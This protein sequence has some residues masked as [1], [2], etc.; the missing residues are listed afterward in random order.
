[1]FGLDRYKKPKAINSK[2]SFNKITN[3]CLNWYMVFQMNSNI[4]QTTYLTTNLKFF[5]NFKE[6]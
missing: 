4:Y 1:M 3:F 2:I 5:S 6:N